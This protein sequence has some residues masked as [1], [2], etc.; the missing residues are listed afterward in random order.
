MRACARRAGVWVLLAASFAA[1]I[2]T[3]RANEFVVIPYSCA[4]VGGRP[5]LT[6]GPEQSHA[7][8]GA[9]EQRTFTACSPANPG[10]CRTWTVHR[11]D[12]DCEGARVPWVSVVASITEET[13]R[14]AWLDS[15][16]LM[17]RMPP[18]WNL[19]PGDPCARPP[20]FDDRYGFGRMRRYCA[21]R[22]A[23]TPPPT[24]E[25]PFG[26]APMLGFDGI[27]VRSGPNAGPGGGPIGPPSP[28]YPPV[29]AGPPASSPPVNTTPPS[30]P[31]KTAR[32]EP[33]PQAEAAPMPASRPPQAAE[34]S[35][36][37][38]APPSSTPPKVAAPKPP[39]QV[40]SAPAVQAPS[41]AAQEPQPTTA[42][43]APIIPKI[44]N[45]PEAANADT[46]DRPQQPTA[47]SPPPAPDVK[48][49]AT[50]P[51]A[52]S[53]ATKT[54]EAASPKAEAGRESYMT[55]N[56]LSAV[57]TPTAGIV[58][59]GALALGLLAAFAI[60]RRR[61]RLAGGPPARDLSAVS[62][63]GG[64]VRGQQ[65]VPRAGSV[66]TPPRPQRPPLPSAPSLRTGTQS[67]APAWADR[68]PQTRSEALQVLGMGVSP[69]ATEA[70]MK[71]V[72]D[73][74]RQSWHP[75][76]ARND[77]DRRLREFRTKQINAAWELIAGKRLERL[78]S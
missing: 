2:S 18:S 44:I 31:P 53:D 76:L 17:V 3:A 48:K 58:A 55:V 14:R 57:R 28:S 34:A 8:I 7:V 39:A 68:I 70:A 1:T 64:K 16:R 6:P 45:R 23:M 51:T 38:A 29:A 65:L 59:F 11:F 78:D 22:R 19:E 36:K 67:A 60:A 42:P 47:T 30:H 12:M 73:G 15:G 21:D 49:A 27:F 35:S 20:S 62:L 25:M 54:S 37:E 46:A 50:A 32:S 13:T 41:P 66:P 63:G 71:K 24:V 26:F 40:T 77:A 43:G 9:R 74:L 69:D 4:M 61:E 10:F 56:L 5:L 52:L 75:D 33:S 72:V